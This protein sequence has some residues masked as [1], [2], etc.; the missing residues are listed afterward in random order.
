M[1]IC[2]SNRLDFISGSD[3]KGE[4]FLE[5]RIFVSLCFWKF[6]RIFESEQEYRKGI[7]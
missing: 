5:T 7:V 1:G 4:L 3:T 6:L 2:R